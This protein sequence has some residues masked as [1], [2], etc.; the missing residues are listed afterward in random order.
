[1]TFAADDLLR[2]I[3]G[4]DP[5]A[6][7]GPGDYFDAEEAQERLDFFPWLLRFTIG[8]R[9]AKKPFMLE[10]WQG[11]IVANLFGW[12]RPDGYRR[13]QTLFLGV[14][15]KN[16]KSE[17]A[18]GL[19]QCVLMMDDEEGAELYCAASS[20][21]Q[22]G[23]VFGAAKRMAELN[24]TLK[25]K[26]ECYTE[27][28]VRPSKSSAIRQ[29]SSKPESKHGENPHVICLDEVHAQK[30]S[31][32]LN[33]LETG[34]GS[35]E[36]PLTFLVTTSDFDRGDS[37]CN[38]RWNYARSVRDRVIEDRSFLPVLYEL[39][40]ELWPRWDEPEVW[41]IVNPNLGVS[42]RE[43]YL[44]RMAAKA[45]AIP[46]FLNVFKRLHL[47][48]RTG[49]AEMWIDLAQWD[50]CFGSEW[51]DKARG[52]PPAVPH[53]V[54]EELL[55]GRD[56]FLGIDLAQTNDIAAVVAVFPLEGGVV[57]LL[58]WFFCPE[59]R[60]V[61]REREQHV[62]YETWGRHGWMELEP[63]AVISIDRIRAR[64]N[65]IAA[66]FHVRS[67]GVDKWQAVQ[68]MDQLQNQDG[69]QVAEVRQHAVSL[70]APSKELERLIG[71]R[72]L[73]HYGNPVLR[74]MAG[75]VAI[76][77][78]PNENIKP[79]KR[80]SGDKIDGIVAAIMGLK[81]SM[82]NSNEPVTSVYETRGFRS[83]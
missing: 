44:A 37:V 46:R 49:Q 6:T 9:H 55:R 11:A 62:P 19:L 66:R 45:K 54:L 42:L 71:S 48:I 77:R 40:K 7:A 63:G 28:I 26:L 18:A 79:D 10:P 38:E 14:P 56:C 3:P 12:K 17:L 70:S 39:P 21:E 5:F 59:E 23:R 22:A 8:K 16:G 4:Y 61:L 27:S 65:D 33:V 57:V 31:E 67:V 13:Y 29:I 60:A 75:N 80:K 34:Q 58:P 50:E 43:E 83:L 64:V 1:M 30:S 78:D 2:L 52:S 74:W 51:A 24:R 15:R 69:L 20:S 72:L 32:L 41:R 81:E 76:G 25:A 53:D 36:Q 47:N 82:L 35:R 73:C 68:L